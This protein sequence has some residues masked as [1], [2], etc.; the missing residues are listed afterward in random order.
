MDHQHDPQ[1]VSGG[2]TNDPLELTALP[3]VDE[4]TFLPLDP[5]YLR[6]RLIGDAIAA[7]VVVVGSVVVAAATSSLI[8][9]AIGLGLLVL[10]A[11]LA[12]L[13]WLEVTHL[14]YLVRDKDFSYRRGVISRAVTTVPF[15]RVQHVSID[16]GPIE[17]YFGLA[18]LEMRTA[19]GGLTVPG[20]DDDTAAR[21]KALVVDRAGVSA[22]EERSDQS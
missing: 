16:R 18:T 9:L 6:V 15:A 5:A 11:L 4:E 12:V 20:V 21:L 3:P 8:P 10:V 13:K 14:G 19:G 22:D 1:H 7:A 17:R 2:F